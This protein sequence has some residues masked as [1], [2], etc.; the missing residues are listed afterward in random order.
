MLFYYL[1]IDLQSNN[2][3]RGGGDMAKILSQKQCEKR[4]W[5][6]NQRMR[7]LQGFYCEDCDTFYPR[8]SETYQRYEYVDTLYLVVANI[9]GDFFR[10][11]KP[12]PTE[13]VSMKNRLE[14]GE[15]SAE[16]NVLIKEALALIR[17]YGKTDRSAIII[18]K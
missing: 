16:L 14:D 17:R 15:K 6:H 9:G 11:K 5:P 8:K 1:V 4:K 18:L 10:S 12:I 3:Q 7:Y 13:I 2:F